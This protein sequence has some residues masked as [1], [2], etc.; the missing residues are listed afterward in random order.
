MSKKWKHFLALITCVSLLAGTAQAG[1]VAHWSLDDGSGTIAH[2][3]SGNGND[4]TLMGGPVWAEQGIAFDGVDD[5]ID[6]G[7]P[8]QL[9]DGASPRSVCA[10]AMTESTANGW[11][12]V[13]GYGS[14]AGSQSNGF[15]INGTLLSGFGYGNDLHVDNFFE[16]GVWYHLCLTYDG[17]T[18][19]L[20][21]NGEELMSQAKDW[22]LVRGFTRIGRQVNSASEFWNG[23]IYDVRIYDHVL[24]VPEILE[25]MVGK[26]EL[27][28]K[29]NPEN[30][31]TDI[32]RNIALGWTSG[33]FAA[34]HDV[35]LGTSYDDVNDATVDDGA[36]MGRQAELSYDP[37]YLALG[38]TYFWRIDE[39]NAAPDKTVFKGNVW[40]F[41]VEPVSYAVPIGAV[42]ATATSSDALVDPS[43]TVNG[44]GLNESDEH[45]NLQ[46]TMWLS[47]ADDVI[48]TIQFELAELQKLDKV[49]IWNHN[50]QTEAILGFGIKEALIEASVDGE[51]WTEV[52]TV[53][54]TQA[55]GM[56]DYV[57]EDVALGGVMARLVKIT[58]LSNFSMLGL[59]QKGLSEVRFYAIPVRAREPEPA[60]GTTTDGV[61]GILSWRSG[62]E[63][64]ESEVVF[65]DDEQAVIDGSAVVATVSEPSYDPGILTLGTAYFWKI[66]E[67][68]DLGTPQA[69][70]GALWTFSTP[71]NLV[72]DDMESYQAQEG[73][74]IW[75]HWV[76][77][78]DNP[79]EN[80][81]VVG[82]GDEAETA[83]VYEGSQSLPI[84]YNNDTAP[85][86]EATLQLDGQ[87]WPASG[88]KTLSLYFHGTEGNTGQLYLKISGT[89]VDYEGDA[90]DLTQGPWRA[91]HIDLSTVGGDLENVKSL[92]V[93]I[94][95]GGAS[96]KLFIDDIRLYPVLGETIEPVEPDAASLLAHYPFDG[97]FSDSAGN[98]DGTALGDAKIVSD[99]D[100]GQVLS[101]DGDDD[102]V[103]IP[104]LA[105]GEEVTISMWVNALDTTTPSDWKS[106]FH[107]DGWTE[108]DIHWR[109]LNN[110]SNGG[111]NGVV[112]SGD[113]TGAGVVP[114]E[115]WSHVTLTLSPTQFSYWLNGIHDVSRQLESAPILQ[116]GDGLIGAY[117]NGEVID[118]EWAGLI[119][120]V[121]IYNR[122]LTAGEVL[123]LSGRTTAVPKPL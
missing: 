56:A 70:E 1:L 49:R 22:N 17:T 82:N 120:D 99:P 108:G 27:S 69:Y 46:E 9:P 92:T 106:F 100:R 78:F 107:G 61:D 102:A 81:A 54:L 25:A 57:G 15:A 66:N 2:D 32:P 76:D 52:G 116:I 55:T 93:G 77:G 18:A 68:N 71:E 84:T 59:P 123:W 104:L 42:S 72:I 19:V 111:V 64:V 23:G 30:E 13:V 53:T 62:R 97:D 95:G 33:K 16:I 34:E 87:D 4:G 122:A 29:P 113:L 21:A 41:A 110:R 73:L 63:A 36:Y 88:A 65:S 11:R 85:V 58:G 43:N 105:E 50:T 35:Y 86:S 38:Q 51:T 121:R 115:Q 89:Q 118:R 117:M 39:V 48:P 37:E 74:F 5:W 80:G 28:S 94:S 40:S 109:Q 83:I 6:I 79:A 24:S 90:D 44:S 14:P 91:W 75:E 31:A 10:W 47:A 7:D 119:D 112:P 3:S 67:M 12:V 26:P 60:D 8:D 98:S 45:T 101:L 96:G 103:D 114:Y 20:Y